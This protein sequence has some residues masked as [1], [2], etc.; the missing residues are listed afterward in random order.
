MLRNVSM[1][2]NR[3]GEFIDP[4]KLAKSHFGPLFEKEV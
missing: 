1:S 4:T 2:V 3:P